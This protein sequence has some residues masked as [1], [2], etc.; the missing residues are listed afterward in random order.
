LVLRNVNTGAF[1]VYNIAN[2][3]ITGAS[4]LGQVALDWQPGSFAADPPTDSMGSS[5]GQPGSTSSDGGFRRW[6]RRCGRKLERCPA[7]RRHDTADVANDTAALMSLGVRTV[8]VDGLCRARVLAHLNSRPDLG[9][10]WRSRLVATAE[11]KRLS[12]QRNPHTSFAGASDC[13]RGVLI[14]AQVASIALGVQK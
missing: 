1:E 2:N 3:Q 5:D 9:V 13:L 14:D 11:E 12:F 8:P 6:Q 10:R 4:L 7:Q